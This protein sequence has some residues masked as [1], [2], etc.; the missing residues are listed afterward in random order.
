MLP[1]NLF[2]YASIYSIKLLLI[3]AISIRINAST[4]TIAELS[5]NLAAQSLVGVD[6]AFCNRQL[7]SSTKGFFLQS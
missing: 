1:L 7:I 3:I 5:V 6:F 4:V 2:Y